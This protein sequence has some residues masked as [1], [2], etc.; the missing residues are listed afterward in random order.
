[1]SGRDRPAPTCWPGVPWGS[2]WTLPKL[3]T[4]PPT[5]CSLECPKLSAQQS[6]VDLGG[7]WLISPPQTSFLSGPQPGGVLSSASCLGDRPGAWRCLQQAAGSLLHTGF[8]SHLWAKR[9]VE[10]VIGWPFPQP[11]L[12]LYPYV[13]CRHDTFWVEGSVGE[14]M[15]PSLYWKS[16]LATGSSYV[17]LHLLCY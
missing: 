11:L 12:H 6:L 5:P 17:S 9:E 7:P 10:P 13:S 4:L 3:Y 2:T 1:M 15:S 14:L 16:Y 8:F